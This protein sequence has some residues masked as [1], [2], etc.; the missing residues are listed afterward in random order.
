MQADMIGTAAGIEYRN[1]RGG[2]SNIPRQ[3][4]TKNS[5]A[6]PPG[7]VTTRRAKD[8]EVKALREAERKK[9]LHRPIDEERIL[10]YVTHL[11]SFELILK[12]SLMFDN[13]GLLYLAT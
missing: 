10:A 12:D 2:L 3:P 8:L 9:Y 13:L 4:S 6:D 5:W 7:L 1:R 11:S